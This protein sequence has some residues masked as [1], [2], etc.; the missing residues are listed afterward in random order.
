MSVPKALVQELAQFSSCEVADALIKL[1]VPHGGFLAGLDMF[2][3]THLAGNT[4]V[5]GP[6]FTVKVR[7]RAYPDGAAE[8]DVGAEARE[9]LCT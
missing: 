7:G 2:S 5:C 4:S 3:P 9:A 6:A 1:K 8:R